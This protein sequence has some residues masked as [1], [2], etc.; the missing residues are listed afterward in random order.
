MFRKRLGNV[1]MDFPRVF[2]DF[3]HNTFLPENSTLLHCWNLLTPGKIL[4]P[5]PLLAQ[6]GT[7]P[8]IG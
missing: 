5:P 2:A 4:H 7:R 8:P 6:K 3:E 1:L